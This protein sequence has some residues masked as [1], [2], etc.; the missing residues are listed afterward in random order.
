MAK[1]LR[2]VNDKRDLSTKTT[3][4]EK[5]HCRQQ[6]IFYLLTVASL[7]SSI[8]IN[9]NFYGTVF[10]QRQIQQKVHPTFAAPVI[11]ITGGGSST[12]SSTK[13]NLSLTAAQPTTATE[14]ATSRSTSS[15]NATFDNSNT[16][17]SNSSHPS[18]TSISVVQSYD[19]DNGNDEHQSNLQQIV[20]QHLAMNV[21]STGRTNSQ[22]Q[23]EEKTL[24]AFI[25]IGKTG[26]STLSSTQLR[27]GCHSFVSWCTEKVIA[28]ETFISKLTTYYHVPAF[29]DKDKNGLFFTT[30]NGND[31]KKHLFYLFTV[32]DPFDRTISS[33]LYSHPVNLKAENPANKNKRSTRQ[34]ASYYGCAPTL[35]DFAFLLGGYYNS[36]NNTESNDENNRCTD[37]FQHANRRS[38]NIPTHLKFDITFIVRNVFGYHSKNTI[39]VKATTANVQKQ[40]LYNDNSDGNEYIINDDDN[41]NNWKNKTIF[42]VRTEHMNDDWISANRYLGQDD[43]TISVPNENLRFRDSSKVRHPVGG[44][45]KLS[46]DGRKNICVSL[47]E[48]YDVYFG[49]LQK[50]GN[51]NAEDFADSLSVAKKNCGSWLDFGGGE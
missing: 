49:V 26:G 20:Q 47:R 40:P 33:F 24:G 15:S 38:K 9:W 36:S 12:N 10:V 50:A 5:T 3:K 48:E 34:Y 21:S 4:A 43:P 46:D 8:S 25:H 51:I 27:Y 42:V 31:D 6:Q 14:S 45:S 19:N 28:N 1:M 22:K 32:R 44:A 39:K 37:M 7:I 35:E 13:S 11:K 17:D 2:F 16:R 29:H 30:K 41:N 23:P 18:R